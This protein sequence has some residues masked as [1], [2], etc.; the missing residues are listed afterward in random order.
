[1]KVSDILKEATPAVAPDNRLPGETKAQ[2]SVR[3]AKEREA[4]LRAQGKASAIPMKSCPP[5]NKSGH[6]VTFQGD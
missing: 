6:G 4:K 3:H 5:I 2:A 1:M